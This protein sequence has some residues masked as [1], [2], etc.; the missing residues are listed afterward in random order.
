MS[1]ED[2]SMVF[3]AHVFPG[4]SEAMGRFRREIDYLNQYHRHHPDA[5]RT[6]LL[7]GETGVGKTYAAK[8]ISALDMAYV[9]WHRG[10]QAL[11]R[12]RG[13]IPSSRT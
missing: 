2:H 6:V 12:F 8:A 1:L 4:R 11:Y 7:R 5:V 10:D 9:G 13:T 3:L